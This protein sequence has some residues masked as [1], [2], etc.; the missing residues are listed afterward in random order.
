MKFFEEVSEEG[1][2]ERRFELEVDG[3][4]VPGIV[5]APSG[6]RGPRP[7][8]L[9]GHGDFQ[10]KRVDNVLALARRMVRHHGYAVAAIDAPGHGDRITPEQAERMRKRAMESA[11]RRDRTM[12]DDQ[13]QSM[14]KAAR[15]AVAEWR[16][17]STRCSAS[18]RSAPG[19]WATGACRWER[20]TAFRSSPPI[21]A[22]SV[23]SSDSSAWAR[24]WTSSPKPQAASRCRY[25]SCSSSTTS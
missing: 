23:R 13:R 19:P 16:G 4:R 21:R 1:V 18:T 25:F 3:Q 2:T 22:S 14:A 6:A 15:Q 5:V 10:H 9:Q 20:A 8:L 17:R 24:I 7:L 12:N 11:G